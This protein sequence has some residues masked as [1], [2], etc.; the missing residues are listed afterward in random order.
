MNS[1]CLSDFISKLRSD[2]I[3]FE[4]PMLAKELAN[5]KMKGF[6]ENGVS[7]YQTKDLQNLSQ[8]LFKYLTERIKIVGDQYK[9]WLE[10]APKL[11]E[12]GYVVYE[13]QNKDL[14]TQYYELLTNINNRFQVFIEKHYD[15]LFSLSGLRHP[16]TI[17]KV[18]D[19][20]SATTKNSRI[21]FIVI[22]GMNYWQWVILKYQL[23]KMSLE[24]DEKSTL[25]WIPSITAWARQAIF[26]GKK[27]DITADNRG[28]GELFKKYW[29]EKNKKLSYHQIAYEVVKTGQKLQVP[30]VDI[31]VAGFVTNGLDDLM[32]GNILGYEQLFINTKLWI[33]KSEICDSIKELRDAGFEVYIS[34]DHGNIEAELKLKLSAG[35]KTLA[36][37]KSKRFIF[38]DTEEQAITYVQNNTNYQLGRKNRFVYFQD[39]NGFGSTNEKV[40]T[41]G[42][43]HILEMLIPVGRVK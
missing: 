42:G 34:T 32:H 17:D 20:I 5:L 35:Q 29:M 24:I 27:P 15:S 25:T 31:T 12:L 3:N 6:I 16:I 28:E 11:G 2:E 39:D 1:D 41:H 14:I 26:A 9:D 30:T 38:F 33:E 23:E 22:D 37:S 19:Y 13:L 8:E 43:S 7:I 4:N 18:Q 36:H 21:T 10:I 40:I